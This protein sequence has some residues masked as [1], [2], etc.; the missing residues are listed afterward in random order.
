MQIKLRLLEIRFCLREIKLR[1]IENKFCLIEIRL[2][3]LKIRF[4]FILFLRRTYW[5]G[6]D[7]N[8]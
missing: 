4:C 6:L 2:R 8:N 7:H 1:L 3:L 5:Q